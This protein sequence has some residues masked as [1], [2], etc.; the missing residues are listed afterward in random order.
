MKIPAEYLIYVITGFMLLFASVAN[1][2]HKWQQ[3]R[4]NEE[5]NFN[6][7]DYMILLILSSFSGV[8]FG[9]LASLK[10]DEVV[11]I[12]LAASVGALLGIDGVHR[13]S[14]M[15]LDMALSTLRHLIGGSK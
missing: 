10:F 3:A 4:Q 2:T 5:V 14:N 12:A 6:H 15:A 9:F 1:A 13:L 7:I 11:V 8:F